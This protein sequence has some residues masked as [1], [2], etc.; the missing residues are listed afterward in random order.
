[1]KKTTWSLW[2]ITW[3]IAGILGGCASSVPCGPE[4]IRSGTFCYEGHDFGRNTDPDYRQGVRD[5]CQT[6]KG[7]FRKDYAR[8]HRSAEYTQ[9]WIKGRTLC[10]PAG[11]SDSPTYSYHPLPASRRNSSTDARNKTRQQTQTPSD[12]LSRQ[13]ILVFPEDSGSST[14]RELE[15]PEV[16]RYPE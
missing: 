4:A 10:R 5:G 3:G 7:Y 1:M 13:P 6:G 8:A 2:V 16:I 15:T 9:G 12:D 11:W 14:H